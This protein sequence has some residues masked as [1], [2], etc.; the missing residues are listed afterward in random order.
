MKS[1][2]WVRDIVRR[3]ANRLY[4]I[5]SER[6]L[7]WTYV[8]F[9]AAARRL[10]RRLAELGVSRGDR[11]A[12]ILNNGPEFVALYFA[13]LYLRAVAAPINPAL[14]P[15]NVRFILEHCGARLVVCQPET[16]HLLP[17]P[18]PP[19]GQTG[20]LCFPGAGEWA[21]GTDVPT[22]SLADAA[23]ES[24]RLPDFGG[25]DPEDLLSI[26][27]TSGSTGRPKAVVHRAISLLEC[28]ALFNEAVGF[29]CH[30][31]LY[32]VFPMA[33][34]AGF[35]NMLLGP[36]MAGASVVL[37]RAF[38][39][40]MTLSF[41]T[42]PIRF[43]VNA[44]WASPTVLSALLRTDR[45]SQGSDYCRRNI[46]RICVG[47]AP[48]PARLKQDFE[49][50]FGTEL[51]ESYGLSETLFVTT[52]RP[53]VSRPMGSVGNAFP[54]IALTIVD[55][56]GNEV[57]ADHEGE[58]RIRTPFL[59]AGY[60]NYE[61]R[62]L[63]PLDA[64]EW[65]SSGDIGRLSPSGD[66]SITGRKKD[67]I[68]RGG[69]NISPREVEDVLLEHPAV[70]RAAVVGTPHEFYGE[71]V[72]AAVQ[73][74]QGHSLSRCESELLGLCKRNLSAVC[75]PSRFV[76]FDPLPT[77]ITG[78]IDKQRIRELV[79]AGAALRRAA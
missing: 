16:R 53:G 10:A 7:H 14:S 26:T 76:E 48:L 2:A 40:R 70:E 42:A 63:D 31:R 62:R 13:C 65:F 21:P 64:A 71:E 19:D 69:L 4:L 49:A 27:F 24:G 11:V 68:I 41:W 3:N 15:R 1:I 67:L 57:P 54:G 37:G 47:T 44:L 66:L 6:D 50:R 12:A 38:D 43:H 55:D 8:A 33:Y 9:D 22:W 29:D 75:V 35:L 61:T 51:L 34:M 58:I 17:G 72:V 78:K 73:C 5:D 36:F 59:M 32:H 18:L 28:A 30:T 79:A 52:N 56:N 45:G 20:T 60:L 25:G 23:A 77:G 74:K 46:A 39:A